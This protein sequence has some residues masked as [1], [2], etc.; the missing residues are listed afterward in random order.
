MEQLKPHPLTE[1]IPPISASQYIA[2]RES[3]RRNGLIEPITL[4]EGKILDGVNRYRACQET[5]TK[6]RTEPLNGHDPIEFILAK[7]LLRRHLDE[8]QRALLA[9]RFATLRDGQKKSA[10]QICAGSGA[11]IEAASQLDAAKALGVG[12]TSVQRAR[13]V[14]EK[15]VPTLVSACERGELSISAASVIANL[16][17]KDQL[18]IVAEQNHAARNQKIREAKTAARE[19]AERARG[20][21]PLR[22]AT[23]SPRGER[24]HYTVVDEMK[25]STDERARVI[26][27]GFDADANMNEQE[28]TSIEWARFSINTVTGCLHNCP[29]C[30]ARDIAERLFPYGFEPVFHPS[31]LSAPGNTEVPAEARHNTAY[32]NVF[33][34]SMSDLFGHWVPA[35]WIEATIDMARRNPQWNFLTLTKFPSRAAEFDVP[36]NWWLGATVDAQAR[37][38]PTEKAFEKIRAKTKWLSIEPML[39]PLKFKRLD[40]FQWIVIGGASASKKTPE[41]IPPF[42][43]LLDLHNQ[44]FAAGCRIYHKTNLG[45]H[46]VARLKEFPWEEPKVRKLPEAL[47]YLKGM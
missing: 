17:V 15:G 37:V 40:L 3:I 9:S 24:T 6:L 26:A 34:N 31:R 14:L 13:H 36:D 21:E 11:P 4:H 5:G 25:L 16:D 27:A 38:A 47:K 43:W 29:Y 12:R 7:V 1:N 10:A 45:L 32:R 42:K 46:D 44:A 2:L 35:W 22:L 33:A 30:Y 18:A 19:K 41:W 23:Q 39:E 8:T 28:S 20:S